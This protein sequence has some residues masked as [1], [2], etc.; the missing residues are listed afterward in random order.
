MPV[1]T[2]CNR[3]RSAEVILHPS[4]ENISSEFLGQIHQRL[5]EFNMQS[6]GQ[7]LDRPKHDN[8]DVSELTEVNRPTDNCEAM[9]SP[10]L[11]VE[12]MRINGFVP[13]IM[14]RAKLLHNF[15]WSFVCNFPRK[16][17]DT[18]IDG[19]IN[20][21]T[22]TCSMLKSF[23]LGLAIENMQ[24]ELFIQIVG[25]DKCFDDLIE[26]CRLGLRLGDLPANDFK[27]LM[28]TRATGRLS[29]VIDILYRLKVSYWVYSCLFLSLN[30][31]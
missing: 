17:N 29:R 23:S 7:G 31:I 26:K 21:H 28:D 16:H 6:R 2:N 1:L 27:N 9:D 22:S 25:S 10:S 19:A 15:L 11:K 4:I 8:K 12:H 3:N 13:A 18:V 24:F 14:V 20:D 5:R 30:I